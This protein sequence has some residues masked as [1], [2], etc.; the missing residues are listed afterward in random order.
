MNKELEKIAFCD[1]SQAGPRDMIVIDKNNKLYCIYESIDRIYTPEV[2]E[3]YTKQD[4]ICTI[5]KK[6]D[7]YF[8]EIEIIS[9][10]I[11]I[12]LDKKIKHFL[13]NS[14]CGITITKDINSLPQRTQNVYNEILSYGN[15]KGYK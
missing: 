13:I 6:Y 7:R 2:V 1:H 5:D 4:S 3:F 8:D 11:D 12:F 15:D 9:E 14:H 10:C